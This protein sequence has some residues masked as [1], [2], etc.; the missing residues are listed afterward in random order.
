[1]KKS[2][3]ILII[4]LTLALLLVSCKSTETETTEENDPTT[5]EVN[6]TEVDPTDTEETDTEEVDTTEE[7][8]EEEIKQE[9]TSDLKDL[10]NE[11][12]YFA[13]LTGY[14]EAMSNYDEEG[15]R[16]L[17]YYTKDESGERHFKLDD[18]N[19]TEDYYEL[20][21]AK[22]IATGLETFVDVTE[23]EEGD[24][25]L[26]YRVK[27]VF[28]KEHYTVDENDE[29][30][31]NLWLHDITVAQMAY[32]VEE[33]KWKFQ[34]DSEM[35]RLRVLETNVTDWMKYEGLTEEQGGWIFEYAKRYNE[36]YPIEE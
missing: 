32:E 29:P 31:R 9:N 20:N 1:M 2:I 11:E 30:D 17:L 33:Q 18:M 5:T 25:T 8:T 15:V 7:V 3:T 26:G 13:A 14:Y 6:E 34:E 36:Q 22:Y 28:V 35:V 19:M 10:Y 12:A 27:I 4:A 16:D 24:G 21:P 23:V